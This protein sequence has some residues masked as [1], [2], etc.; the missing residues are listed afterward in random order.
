MGERG[1]DPFTIA[2]IMAHSDI[3]MTRSYTQATVNAK[4]WKEG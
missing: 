1:V 4:P 2:E 3:K